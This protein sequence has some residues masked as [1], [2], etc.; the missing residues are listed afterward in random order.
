MSPTQSAYGYIAGQKQIQQFDNIPIPTPIGKQVLLKVEA[1]GLCLSDPHI[2]MGGPLESKPPMTNATKFVMGHE[3]AGSISTVGNDLANDPRY[4][5][6]GRFALQIDKACGECEA[7]RQG[8]DSNCTV[9]SQAYGL[10]EDG[11]F[12]QYLLVSNLRTLLPIPDGVSY[13][14]AAV[15]TDSVLTP[16]HAIQKVKHLIQPT[17]KILVQGCGGLGLNA[18]QIL[19]NYNC[20]IV[21]TDVKPQLKDLA[22]E[23]GANEYHTDLSKSSHEPMSF[24]LIF[25]FV[26]IQPTFDTSEKYIKVRGKILMIG[27]GRSKLF[28]PNYKLGVREV[29]I[30]FNFGGTSAEQIEC[31][32]WVSKGLIKPNVTLADFKDLPKYLEDLNKGKLTGRIVFRP[33][34]MNA[35]PYFAYSDFKN[36]KKKK[37]VLFCISFHTSTMAKKQSGENSKKA[38]GNARKAEQASKKKQEAL[39]RLEQEEASKWD[40]GS[41]K[42]NKKKE[43]EQFKKEEAARKKAER[44]AL[45]AAEEASMPSKPTKAKNRGAE[46]VAQRRTGKIDDFLD[47]NKDIPELSASG[48]DSALEALA[49]TSQCGGVSNKDIDRHPERRVKAAYNAYEEKRLAE[50]RK[51]NPGLRL[52]QIKNLIFKEFQKSPENPM[53]QDTNVDFNAS[54]HDIEAKKTEVR[55]SREKKF[56]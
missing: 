51:E 22:L 47:F 50:V 33:N 44:D 17:T 16:F 7:C 23:Y 26:G 5:I 1:A 12:Q 14:V 2:L 38:Q 42:G 55:S 39:D 27:L 32:R 19:K 3:I 53:N 37:F 15:T 30:I 8:D 56:T 45:L 48:L 31:M 21:A 34:L 40:E 46:K 43:D 25:D 49:L 4:K 18:V 20:Y 54:R 29:E 28:I 36:R 6:G 41:K 11:G 35:F 52:N 10:N 9:T 13:E 24:D